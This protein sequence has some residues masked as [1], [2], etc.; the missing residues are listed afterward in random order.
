[1]KRNTKIGAGIVAGAAAM[2]VAAVVALALPATADESGTPS[3]TT[4]APSRSA[5]AEAGG[6]HQ[7]C[8][9]GGV[10]ETLLTGDDAAKAT[11]AAEK[12]VEGGTVLRVETDSE[13]VYEAHVRK[14]D[15]TEV[16]VK[17]DNDFAVT[18]VDE[19]T[20]GLHGGGRGARIGD[21]GADSAGSGDPESASPST[22][23]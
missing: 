11:A 13:G 12:A 7:G 8:D 18:S 14:A 1:M 20:G 9:P 4:S 23:A 17:L 3:P 6:D 15:G 21:Q 10:G 16:V 22:S 5:P 19:F 2:T